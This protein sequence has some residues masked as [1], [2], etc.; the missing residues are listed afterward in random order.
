MEVPC[1]PRSLQQLQ[2]FETKAGVS[3]EI[4]GQVQAPEREDNG[5]QGLRLPFKK[6]LA[7]ISAFTMKASLRKGQGVRGGQK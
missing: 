2:W 1:F 7:T 5:R 6:V 3:R 4:E